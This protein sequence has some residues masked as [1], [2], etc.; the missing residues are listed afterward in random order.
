MERNLRG[1]EKGLGAVTQK[2]GRRGK[3]EESISLCQNA[4]GTREK[5]KGP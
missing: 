2:R 1:G 3:K 4:R 5:P